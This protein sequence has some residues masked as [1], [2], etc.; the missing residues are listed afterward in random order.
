MKHNHVENALLSET[1]QPLRFVG[2]TV[3][4]TFLQPRTPPDTLTAV[5]RRSPL[6][7]GKELVPEV[8]GEE[9]QAITFRTFPVLA[10]SMRHF[11]DPEEDGGREAV[12]FLRA[13]V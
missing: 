13:H 5:A 8:I 10:A 6:H 1:Y 3:H 9:D 7:L 12:C 2:S 11:W 4:R